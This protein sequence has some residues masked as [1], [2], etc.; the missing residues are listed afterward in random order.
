ML[1]L[2]F[3]LYEVR[4]GDGAASPGSDGA[5]ADPRLAT[6]AAA[7]AARLG[8]VCRDWDAGEFQAVV[9][10]IARTKLRWADRGYGE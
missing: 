3:P 8:A 7:L 6:L 2:G 5:G 4:M 1:T 9:E 10:R